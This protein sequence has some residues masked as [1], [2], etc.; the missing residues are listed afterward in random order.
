MSTGFRKYRIS[1][2]ALCALSFIVLL[3]GALSVQAQIP[4]II[5][6]VGDT[7]GNA[8]QQNSMTTVSLDNP[9]QTVSAF[10]L[11]LQLDRPDIMV[12]KTDTV[13]VVD[14]TY[15]FCR[16][17]QGLNCVDSVGRSKNETWNIRHIDTVEA[18]V[19][20]FS[21]AGTLI[22]NWEYV[23]ARSITG[24]GFDIKV[25]GIADLFGSGGTTPGISPQ[26]GGVL[27]RLLGD[28]KCVPDSST[29]RTVYIIPQPFLDHFNFSRPDGTSIGIVT[30]TVPDTNYYRCNSWLPP[31]NQ[32][33]VNYV[34]VSGVPYDSIKIT[35]DTVATLDTNKVKLY[36]GSLTVAEGTECGACGNLDH[37]P[38]ESID[39][40]DLTVLIDFLFITLAPIE[41]LSIGNLDCDAEGSVDIS[42]LTVLIDYLFIS[43]QDMCC[44]Q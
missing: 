32:V 37:D 19:G 3:G 39:I 4:D 10:E 1:F 36:V 44:L 42:D 41:P 8:G 14:T 25:T 22:Q 23:V 5:V 6:T 15:W 2:G 24:S 21:I 26:S 11:W 29:D 30:T 16:Q 20:S 28:I 7:V 43:L 31:D 38:A 34:Q 12:F 18:V 40:S 33:C 27:F 17:Y 13:P 9:T 35:L